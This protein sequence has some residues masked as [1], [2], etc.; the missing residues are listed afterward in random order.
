MKKDSG[1]SIP[2]QL[3]E[4]RKVLQD[5]AMEKVDNPSGEASAY[6]FRFIGGVGKV[7]VDEYFDTAKGQSLARDFGL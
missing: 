5:I 3:V 4:A 2:Y 1:K 7:E 6:F